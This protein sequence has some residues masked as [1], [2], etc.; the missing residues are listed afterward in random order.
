MLL[1]YNPQ[2]KVESQQLLSRGYKPMFKIFSTLLLVLACA[3]ALSLAQTSN[4]QKSAAHRTVAL[5]F[6]DLPYAQVGG[7]NYVNAAKR[8]TT[9]MLRVLKTHHAPAV[10][11]VNES[12]LHA[13]GE[14][15]ARTALLKQWIDAGMTLGN[16]TYSHADFNALT[17]EQFQD[18]I[19]KGDVITRRLMESRRP[20]QLYF[21]HPMTRTGNTKEKKE[22]IE[23]FLTARK[24]KIMPHTIENSDFIFNVGYVYSKLKT[25]EVM[26]RRL[27]EAYLDLTFAAT[28]IAEKISPQIF[29]REIP[30]ILLLH[31]NDINADCLDELLGGFKARGYRFITMEDAMADPAYQTVDTVVSERGPTWLWRWS[32]SLGLNISF[33]D[34]PD[35]PEW[36]MD[37]YSSR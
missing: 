33:K 11:V 12:K 16:H 30:Q 23:R 7:G 32:R 34:D 29:G 25:D 31:A 8:G 35:P 19:I 6:D 1:S 28:S 37:L 5:T 26:A 18:E 24:Y 21:R 10:G 17:V 14:L 2:R 9:E 15:E 36:V 27:R 4:P 22:A 20:Y 13:D 3:G